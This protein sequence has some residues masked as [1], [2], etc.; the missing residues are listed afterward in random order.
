MR[1]KYCLIILFLSA[2]TIKS[3]DFR[4]ATGFNG[5]ADNREY[6]YKYTMPQTI[7]GARIYADIGYKID[8]YQW[9]GAGLNYLYEFGSYDSLRRPEPVLY[10]TYVKNPF[11]FYIGSFSRN[12]LLEYPKAL[13]NDTLQYYR[14]N[15]EG[16]YLKFSGTWG[17]ENVW[18]DWTSRQ[19]FNKREVFLFGLS[20]VKN[21]NNLFVSHQFLMLHY[22]K[23]ANKLANEYIRDNG[24]F[25]SEIGYRFSENSYFDKLEVSTG[26]ILGLDRKRSINKM[27][28]PVGS[29]T[30][31]KFNI[32]RVGLMQTLYFGEKQSIIYGDSFY[33]STQYSRTDLILIPIKN[34]YIESEFILSFHYAGADLNYSQSFVLRMNIDRN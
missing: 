18:I 5:F 32:K 26:F 16:M 7:F 6:T 9:F 34:E 13:L 10:Y 8:D 11:K 29:Y 12:K 30:Q 14:P 2:T 28:F 24:A 4:Y 31:I 27:N 23:S 21:F 15:I 20:G 17:Y 1:I 25:A 22:A 19:T 3:Q 33:Q